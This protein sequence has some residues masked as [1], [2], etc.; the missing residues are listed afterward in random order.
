M[1][2]GVILNGGAAESFVVTTVAEPVGFD[3]D[4]WE[5]EDLVATVQFL[6]TLDGATAAAAAAVAGRQDVQLEEPVSFDEDAV[7]EPVAL[8]LP[9]SSDQDVLVDVTDQS[10]PVTEEQSASTPCS[11]E[12]R[13]IIRTTNK[14]VQLKRYVRVLINRCTG[15]SC[16]RCPSRDYVFVSHSVHVRPTVPSVERLYRCAY[17]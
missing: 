5:P 11:V 2:S 12:E 16:E 14:P 15:Q 13:S 4:P 10:A 8:S 7:V 3:V 6:A 17:K 1:S 9:M